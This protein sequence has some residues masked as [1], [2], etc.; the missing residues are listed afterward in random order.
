MKK[1]S[2]GFL[3]ALALNPQFD[4]AFSCLDG[5][6]GVKVGRK[7]GCVDSAGKYVCNPTN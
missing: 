6:A 5:L 3:A 7:I 4:E 2:L 1:R